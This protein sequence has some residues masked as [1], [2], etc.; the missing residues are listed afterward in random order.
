[1]L[2]L[3]AG[4]EGL[5]ALAAVAAGAPGHLSPGGTLLVEHGADQG[6]AVRR[7]FSHAG[8]EN[9]ETFAD[10]VR[11]RPRDRGQ[12]APRGGRIDA[13]SNENAM[14]RFETSHGDFTV[15]VDAESA[16]VSAKNFLRYVDESFFDGTIFH[17]VIP[18]FMI[19]GGGF[20]A[21]MEHKA[22]HAPIRNEADNGLKN[23]RG[24]LAMA[25]TNDL[26]SA[27]SQFFV[28]LVDNDF[29][30]HRTGSFG[31]AVFGRVVAGMDTVDKI[32]KVKTGR[33]RG[34]DDVPARC[35]RHPLRT[36][37]RRRLTRTPM[38]RRSL[39]ARIARWITTTILSV[40]L[41]SIAVVAAFRWVPVPV[42]SFMINE[43][44]ADR[45]AT[46]LRQRHVWVPWER[47]SRNA[48]IAVIASE[49]QKFLMHDGFDFDAIGK[50]VTDA[51]RGRR[52]RGAST[53]SQQVAKN[54]FLWPGQSWV[55]KGLEVWFHRVDRV[56]LA[57][58]ADPRGLP[59]QRP[60]RPRHLG[61]RRPRAAR[62]SEGRRAAHAPGRGPARR[63]AAE[64]DTL[65]LSS[66][67]T[68]HARPPDWILHQMSAVAKAGLLK[69]L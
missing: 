28:N 50:A 42:T 56:P 7:L 44:L 15:E 24:S 30:N 52:L 19:Q 48:A 4:P 45:G 31:Y 29:L 68:L 55:R 47:I 67:R 14:V 37:R 69:G 62:T 63:R 2:A 11:P 43:R 25:R 1:M 18:G 9:I 13:M 38:E 49:D 53:I 3:A 59:Q 32:A 46:P 54:L 12:A 41:G 33:Q 27:T 8:L 61:R 57:E 39:A 34:H 65:P 35:G 66:I 64:P 60:V 21:E 6:A 26:H 36:A 58:A 10:P 16:P 5:E 17:R 23:Q 22:G 40:A 20:S 51:Q